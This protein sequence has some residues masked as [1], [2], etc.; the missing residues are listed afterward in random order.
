MKSLVPV[1]G[2]KKHTPPPHTHT[3]AQKTAKK[4]S[5]TCRFLTHWMKNLRQRFYFLLYLDILRLGVE[6]L[7]SLPYYLDM[8]SHSITVLSLSWDYVNH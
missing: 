1:C 3:S 7:T 4:R 8:D 5:G 2:R 6:L